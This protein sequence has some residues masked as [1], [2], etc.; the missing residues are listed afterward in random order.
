[1]ET[2]DCMLIA[3]QGGEMNRRIFQ[4][5][6]YKFFSLNVIHEYLPTSPILG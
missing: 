2:W 3:E 6:I 5:N 4:A 1:M